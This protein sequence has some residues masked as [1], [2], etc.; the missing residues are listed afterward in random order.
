MISA[1]RCHVMCRV[2]R[3]YNVLSIIKLHAEKAVNIINLIIC[4]DQDPGAGRIAV[5]TICK[6]SIKLINDFRGKNFTV[7][8]VS[9]PKESDML[10]WIRGFYCVF[11]RPHRKRLLAF[12]LLTVWFV[13]IFIH[14]TFNKPR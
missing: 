2:Y 4:R 1:K 3:P 7:N 12:N 10:K 5:C 13:M 6:S 9:N 8:E 11:L 14:S